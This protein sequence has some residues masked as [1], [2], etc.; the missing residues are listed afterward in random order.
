MTILAA[1]I[2]ATVELHGDP[3]HTTA[4]FAVKHMVVTTV[5]GEFGKVDSTLDWD[6]DDPSKSKV[7]L[8]I[9]AS[10]VDT[11]VEK[12]D[13]HLKSAD[14]FDVAKC[15]KITFKSNKVE[16]A[17]DGQYKVTGDLT[18]HCQTHPATLDVAFDGKAIKSPWGTTVYAA[19][20]T[21]KIKRSEWGLTWNKAL[22]TGGALVS[23]DVD[24]SVDIEFVAKPAEAKKE[25]A[26]E[27]K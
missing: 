25:A 22:E 15:P 4:Q 20:A 8:D 18:M 5:R 19:S 6:K 7:T 21:G 9:D 13:A 3:Q 10:T 26:A 14:F 17:G 23:D 24:L 11:H 27:K 12:R 16:K 1:L 2:A